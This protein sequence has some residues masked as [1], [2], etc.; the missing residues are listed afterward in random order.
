MV[1]IAVFLV[2]LLIAR[3]CLRSPRPETDTGTEAAPSSTAVQVEMAAPSPPGP[4]FGPPTP[5]RSWKE[6]DNP[7][8]YMPTG[9]G[10]VISASYGSVRTRSSGL[11]SFH[12]GVDVAPVEWERGRAT[13]PIFA[14]AD[15]EVAYINK[16][17]GNS[18]Y[19][20]YVVLRHPDPVGDV[21]TLYAH[22]ASVDDA[23]RTGNPVSRGDTLGIMGHSSTLGIPRQRSHLHFE[24]CMMLNP[25]FRRW[26]RSQKLKP[27]HNRYHG[28]NFTGL[29]PHLLLSRLHERDS[30]PF[31]FQEALNQTESA[32][33]I[34]IATPHRPLYFR[35]YPD[36]WKGGSAVGD[37]I[38]LEVSESGA[39]LSGRAAEP[40]E[41]EALGRSKTRILEVNPDV[42]GRNGTRHILKR[43]GTWSLGSNG[44]RW[45]EILLFR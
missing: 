29:N 32:W 39:I 42:L 26:Y 45:L 41:V 2:L 30:A 37:A 40:A 11:A 43:N 25:E 1:E 31:T 10:R 3:S 16:V 15:G 13:D 8:V 17:G 33:T 20:I 22:L 7:K 36:L 27:D 44:E 5:Q 21:Y 6:V 23:L 9:S 34:A 12:E 35:M 19:G 38:V 4:L 28:F 18:S 14:V 24:I